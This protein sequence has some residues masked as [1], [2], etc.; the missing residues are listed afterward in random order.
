MAQVD[1]QTQE[2]K[3]RRVLNV[4]PYKTAPYS[5]VFTARPGKAVSRQ[6]DEKKGSADRLAVRAFPYVARKKINR[7]CFTGSA[8]D[9]SELIRLDF[10]TLERPRK[11]ISG[12]FPSGYWSGRT[13]D[14]IYSV[15]ISA[16]SLSVIISP[17][18]VPIPDPCA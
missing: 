7:P 11:A 16:I 1:K 8:A 9:F 10:P 2:Q 5:T 6:I 3:P 4:I 17:T 12:L 15:L 13:A 14:A 18:P